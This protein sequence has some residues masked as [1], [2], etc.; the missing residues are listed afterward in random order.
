MLSGRVITYQGKKYTLV[1]E[2]TFARLERA[3]KAANGAAAYIKQLE[4]KAAAADQVIDISN[5]LEKAYAM[6]DEARKDV[7]DSLKVAIQAGIRA[8]NAERE[9]RD[10]AIKDRDKARDDAARANKRSFWVGVIAAI[11]V[12]LSRL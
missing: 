3:V 12:A 10:I 1:D 11:A 6:L 9:A 7:I 2:L 5:K 8:E 4:A